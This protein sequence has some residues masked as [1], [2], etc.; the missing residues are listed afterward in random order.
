MIELDVDDKFF[1]EHDGDLI[2]I[3]EMELNPNMIK[4]NFIALEGTRFFVDYEENNIDKANSRV[5]VTMSFN[6]ES[7]NEVD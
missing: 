4:N 3:D 1:I 6:I 2:L 7:I 5:V